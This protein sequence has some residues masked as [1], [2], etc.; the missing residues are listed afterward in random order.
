[1]LWAAPLMRFIGIRFR[2]GVQVSDT[3]VQKYF[4]QTVAPAAAGRPSRRAV[5][6]EDY[7]DQIEEKL[8][9]DLADAEMN[10]W[11]HEAR[12]RNEIIVHDEAF[13]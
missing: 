2:P 10:V 4:D 5:A 9:G 8:A 3:E 7:R 12:N 1:M 11:L 6:I 13:Q